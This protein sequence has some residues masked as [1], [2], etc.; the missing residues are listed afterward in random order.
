MVILLSS[1]YLPPVQY[2]SKFFA[3]GH[4]LIEKYENFQ[5]QSYRNRCYIYGANGPQCLV[6]PVK[7]MHGTKSGIT[8][9]EIDYRD[10]WTKI[11]LKSIQSAYQT[12]PFYEYYADDFNEFYRQPPASLFEFNFTLLKYMLNLLEI[13][14]DVQF[15]GEFRKST[16]DEPDFRQA[17]HPKTRMQKPDPHFSPFPYQ[18]VFRE[19]YGFLPNLSIIDLIFNEG[20]GARQVIMSGII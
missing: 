10:P 13:N 19:R 12:S 17:I 14:T 6:V 7:K 20:P 16:P 8:E 11:H 4:V 9:V 15:T 1:A 2:I 5:K 18:Q 3:G